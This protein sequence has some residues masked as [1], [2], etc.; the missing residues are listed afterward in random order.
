[1]EKTI[2]I[3]GTISKRELN[4]YIK[5]PIE[6]AGGTPIILEIWKD[7]EDYRRCAKG[8]RLVDVKVILKLCQK[9]Q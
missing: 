6:E 5:T 1:M 9:K 3:K 8:E 2:E 7:K 4:W